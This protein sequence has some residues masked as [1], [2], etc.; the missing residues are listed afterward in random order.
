MIADIVISNYYFKLHSTRDTFLILSTST[1]LSI[2]ITVPIILK[3]P[4]YETVYAFIR[5][6]CFGIEPKCTNDNRYMIIGSVELDAQK[7]IECFK[8]ARKT[9]LWRLYMEKS[10]LAKLDELLLNPEIL[11]S[12]KHKL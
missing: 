5:E 4:S 1:G 2:N 10:H 6:G 9:E 12:D 11:I 7:V 3:R 8:E